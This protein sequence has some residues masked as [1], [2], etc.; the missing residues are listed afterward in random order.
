MDSVQQT[1]GRTAVVI[2]AGPAGLMAAEGLAGRGFAVTVIERMPSPARKFLMAGRG[3]LNLTHSEPLE[4]FLGRYGAA[5]PKLEPMIRAFDPNHLRDWCTS[6]GVE[7]FVGSS[8][9]VFPTAFKAAPMLR[10]WLRR[11]DG[12]GVRLL[13]RTQW[14]G[15]T[16]E[17]AV[18]LSGPEGDF[19]LQADVCVLA[20]GGASWPRL[21]SDGGWVRALEAE[22]VSVSPFR[23]ANAG[24]LCHWSPVFADRFAGQP[25]KPVRVHAADRV[26]RGE[27]MVTRHGL[28]GGGI[29]AVLPPLREAFEQE[30]RALVS[31]DLMP[32]LTLA[33][34]TDKLVQLIQKAGGQSLSSVL[35]RLGLGPVALGLLRE[36]QIRLN[37]TPDLPRHAPS[38]AT[39]IKAVPILVTGLAGL[40][41]AISSAGGVGWDSVSPTLELTNRPGVWVCGEMLDWEA[42]TGGY[43]LQACLASGHWVGRHAG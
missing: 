4:P 3:G 33:A 26:S 18:A 28:E 1:Q 14:Q 19:S 36:G 31:L 13:T 8:G 25:L 2:G 24:V 37:G 11:L 42:P 10:A 16:P 27:V 41:R 7:T 9:R 43:L 20:L 39:L 38:L 21:G 5:R 40:E 22:G 29:Y 34:L 30:G 17:G 12:A 15:W 23:P 35:K 6:L 32:D